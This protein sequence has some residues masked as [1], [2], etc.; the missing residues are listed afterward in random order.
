NGLADLVAHY[1][2]RRLHAA[3]HSAGLPAGELSAVANSGNGANYC[4]DRT[5]AARIPHGKSRWAYVG[6]LGRGCARS[7]ADRATDLQDN[8]AD[9]R[10]IVFED[11]F[12]FSQSG[13]G[14]IPGAGHV[15]AGISV[16]AT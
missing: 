1:L 7:P 14:G 15:V 3:D 11:R 13:P 8:E 10:D 2:G 4:G 6:R 9:F 5:D 12:E 16:A